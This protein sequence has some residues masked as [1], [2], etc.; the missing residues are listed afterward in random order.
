MRDVRLAFVSMFAT[1]SIAFFASAEPVAGVTAAGLG[2]AAYML[3][4]DLTT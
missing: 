1:A 4:E 3:L 2:L